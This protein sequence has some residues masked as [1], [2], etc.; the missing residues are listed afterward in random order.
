MWCLMPKVRIMHPLTKNLL[1]NHITNV[2]P[3]RHRNTT[4]FEAPPHH[5]GRVLLRK[6]YDDKVCLHWHLS[7]QFKCQPPAPPFVLE[8]R[9]L[10]STGNSLTANMERLLTTSTLTKCHG[11]SFSG[12]T[13]R[14][15]S[16]KGSWMAG[17]FS[18][19]GTFSIV[20]TTS[21]ILPTRGIGT[22]NS[23]ALLR[24]KM[25]EPGVMDNLRQWRYA[26]E[27]NDVGFSISHVVFGSGDCTRQW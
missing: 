10:S 27:M 17:K 13:E 15:A 20:S 4:T 2:Y 24:Y 19:P 8:E 21:R 23:S 22:S 18:L 26:V 12:A 9:I 16:W 14:Q 11:R 5:Q 1:A 3:E 7:I 25:D 6:R